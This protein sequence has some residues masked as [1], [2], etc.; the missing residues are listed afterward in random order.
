MAEPLKPKPE[1]VPFGQALERARRKIQPKI[2]QEELALL[3]DLNRS[4]VGN[5]ER[6]QSNISLL[7]LIKIAEVLKV[8]PSDLLK[9]AGL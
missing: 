2:S 6:G 5:L 1:L 4:Y 9:D 3:S 7:K 8:K